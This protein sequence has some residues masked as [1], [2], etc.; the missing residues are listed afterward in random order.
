MNTTSPGFLR[1]LFLRPALWVAMLPGIIVVLLEN[2]CWGD[3]PVL[4]STLC[5]AL[6]ARSPSDA[7]FWGMIAALYIGLRVLDSRKMWCITHRIAW[8]TEVALLVVGGYLVW[9]AVV[10]FFIL[11]FKGLDW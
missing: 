3:Q 9:F 10:S 6:V 4:G 5:A 8:F 1:R 7:L 2:G 11:F